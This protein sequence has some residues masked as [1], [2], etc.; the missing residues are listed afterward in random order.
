MFKRYPEAKAD[1]MNR[2]IA[3]EGEIA[4]L[5][6]RIDAYQTD[7]TAKLKTLETYTR[8]LNLRTSHE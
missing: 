2:I 8:A 7:M 6:H 4:D 3:M 5:K 1:L